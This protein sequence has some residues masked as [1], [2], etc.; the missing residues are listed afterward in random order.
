MFCDPY[1]V[2]GT[3]LE[4]TGT[5]LRLELDC[6]FGQNIC[7]LFQDFSTTSEAELDYYHQKVN[8]RNSHK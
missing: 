7:R 6:K 8:I 1:N 3:D 2:T 5:D 4:M